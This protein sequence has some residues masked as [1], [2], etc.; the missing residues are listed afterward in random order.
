MTYW[1]SPPF[2]QSYAPMYVCTHNHL[3]NYTQ[4]MWLWYKQQGTHVLYMCNPCIRMPHSTAHKNLID[5]ESS[6][7]SEE[8][9][10]FWPQRPLLVTKQFVTDKDVRTFVVKT[11]YALLFTAGMWKFNVDQVLLYTVA[12]ASTTSQLKRLWEIPVHTCTRMSESE[13]TYD[14][15]TILIYTGISNGICGS[16]ECMEKGIW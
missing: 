15:N 6:C 12:S 7:S 5:I 3:M 2:S 14:S 4:C 9:K 11:S 10:A 13:Y 8:Q 1:K 16:R